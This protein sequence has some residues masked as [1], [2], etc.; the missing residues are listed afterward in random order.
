MSVVEAFGPREK[1]EEKPQIAE[2]S[3]W[4][5][6]AVRRIRAYSKIS[7][8]DIVDP[9]TFQPK[10]YPL[11]KEVVEEQGILR[12]FNEIAGR[13][14][15]ADKEPGYVFRESDFLPKGTRPGLA[16]GIPP[17]KRGYTIDVSKVQGLVGLYPGDHFDM[18]ATIPVD[19]K[20]GAGGAK[21]GG[22]YGQQMRMIEHL[23]N[24]AKQAQ[25]KVVVQNGKVVSGLRAR[26]TPTSSS[27]LMSG[28]QQGTLVVQEVTIALDPDEVA[29]LSEAL[30]VGAEIT[31]TPRSGHPDDP[32]D[33]V[34][35]DLKPKSPFGGLLGD[36]EEGEGTPK[37]QIIEQVIGDERQL[38]PVPTGKEPRAAEATDA[39]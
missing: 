2:D 16:A 12:D 29:K 13:V 28:T 17:G 6:Q 34:T 39:R 27:S 22:L 5:P 31:C 9:K 24:V 26:A 35:P 3:V 7:R 8:D 38:V 1:A 18:I 20:I 19:D 11:K 30:A 32:T 21:Y 15:K 14:L 25:V 10:L 33:S 4:V 36:G 37:F 23:E